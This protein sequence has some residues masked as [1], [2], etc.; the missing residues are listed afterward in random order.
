M[1]SQRMIKLSIVEADK[2]TDMP[3]S[4]QFFYYNLIMRADDDG[5]V[6]NLRMLKSFCGADDNDISL[7]CRKGFLYRFESGIVLIRHWKLHNH[8]RPSIHQDTLYTEELEQVVLS[9][10]DIY[11]LK[12]T[13]AD[14]TN[15][16]LVSPVPLSV[17]EENK[18]NITSCP[19]FASEV[20]KDSVSSCPDFASEVSKGKIS[21]EKKRK[22]KVS[23]VELRNGRFE[24]NGSENNRHGTD[25]HTQTI[26]CII[27]VPAVNGEFL[28]TNELYDDLTHTYPYIDVMSTLEKIQAYLSANP[29]KQRYRNNTE[30]YLRMWLSDDA[31]KRTVRRAGR[32]SAESAGINDIS[33]AYDINEAESMNIFDDH[34]LDQLIGEDFL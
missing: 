31:K 16:P 11:E 17:S 20:S 34:E 15:I 26:D 7:L 24:K 4:A 1:A 5:F 27:A 25:K 32:Q 18:D 21:E 23:A 30:G 9:D 10:K 29:D 22:S 33:Y 8:I 13:H 6:G 14:C 2:F 19:D 3:M 28:V 12:D